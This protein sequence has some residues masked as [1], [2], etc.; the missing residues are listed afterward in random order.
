M[1]KLLVIY[2]P[3]SKAANFVL[4]GVEIEGVQV[5]P[6]NIRRNK[7]AKAFFYLFLRLGLFKTAGFFRYNKKTRQCL[8][9]GSRKVL[10]YDCCKLKEYLVLNSLI[11]SRNKTIFFWNPLVIWSKD[12]DFL[13]S[14]LNKL[15]RIGYYLCSFDSHD[16][17]E[18]NIRLLKNINRRYILKENVTVDYD[19]YFV[20]LPKGREIVL[21]TIEKALIG[22]GFK[23][24]FIIIK[25]SSSYI[26]QY[27]NIKY[28]SGARCIVDIVSENQT[29]LTLR[30]F[31]ALF[32]KKKI[33]TNSKIIK[34]ADFYH[35]DNIYIIEDY[36]LNGIEDFMSK[37]YH[38]IPDDIINQYE[39]NHWINNYF[40]QDK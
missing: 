6:L 31:D 40:L 16:S 18:Y 28:S 34:D 8:L 5:L 20:G 35:P 29:G 22:K 11:S 13:K 30:P 37:P 17:L 14:M 10:L 12:P 39:V 33:I 21:K 25:D 7:I 24:N 4:E 19:F 9:Q 27:D 23:T 3:Q 1:N 2:A 36:H 26:S 32:L 38:D 15:R